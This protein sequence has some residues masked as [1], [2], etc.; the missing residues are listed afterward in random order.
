MPV[1]L[2]QPSVLAPP[3]AFGC[4]L[5]FR[6][7]PESDPRP[8]L[9][10]LQRDF[11]PAWGVVG[12]GEPLLR[13]LGGSVPGL[14]TFPSLSGAG[15]AVPSTQEDLW[16]MLR[17]DDRSTTFDR[18]AAVLTMLDGPFE[19]V[20][21]LD[22]FLYQSGR[23]LTGYED[24]T[25][26]PDADESV[27]VAIVT[28]GNAAPAGSSFVA[29]QRWQH[30][31][32]RFNAHSKTERDHIIGRERESNDELEDAPA[33]AH[34]KRSAQESF[35]PEAFLVRRSMP[36][37]RGDEQGLEFISFGRSFDAFE[38]ILQRM[39]GQEDGIVDALFRFSRPLTGSYYWCPPVAD[40]RLNLAACTT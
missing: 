6:I 17:G 19:Q 5:T 2:A 4:S 28:D 37:A 25:E 3:P 1:L 30:D 36:W 27:A 21:A 32:R 15:C 13:L 40:G 39:V 29:V 34:V 23:D 9:E 16:I 20:D 7:R 11:D 24:G 14:R 33:S 12:L 31:L 8:A 10:R 38:A 26:N 18:S 22:T 35:A